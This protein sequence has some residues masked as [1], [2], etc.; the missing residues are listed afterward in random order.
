MDNTIYMFGIPILDSEY[1]DAIDDGT[2]YKAEKWHL[3]DMEK[4]TDDYVIIGFDGSLKIYEAEGE[5]LFDGSL[6]DSREFWLRLML[7]MKEKNI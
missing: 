2:Q 1:A 4:Y 7:K 5:K 3:S 6:L